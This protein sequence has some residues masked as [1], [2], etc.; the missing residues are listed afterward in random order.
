MIDVVIRVAFV[1][2]D[3]EL[4]SVNHSGFTVW[5]IMRTTTAR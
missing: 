1:E 5:Q 3:R 4:A 2:P